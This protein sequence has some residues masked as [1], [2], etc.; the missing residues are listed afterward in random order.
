MTLA[1]LFVLLSLDS[2]AFRAGMMSAIT[3]VQMLQNNLRGMQSANLASAGRSL[4]YGLTVPIIAAAAAIGVFGS[5]L[6]SELARVQSVISTPADNGLAQVTQWRDG[7]Q[8]LAITLGRS[9]PEVAGGMYEIVSALGNIPNAMEYLTIAGR[10]AVAGQ[11]DIV[12]STKN[13]VLATRAWGDTSTD[14][15]KYMANL[16]SA[17]VRVGT[18]TESELGPAMANLLPI[19]RLYNVQ[20]ESLFSGIA[21][22]AGVSGSA[23]QAST[24]L[25]RAIISITSPNTALAGAYK[26]VGISSGE[27]LL[28]QKGLLGSFQAIMDISTRLNIPL[29]KLLGRVEAVKAVATLTE[30][31]LQNFRDNLADISN[32][33]QAVDLAFEGT[34]NGINK[35]AFQW[36][37][38]GVKMQVIAEDLYE[39][40]APASLK[41][42]EALD[43]MIGRLRSLADTISGMSTENVTRLMYALIGLAALGPTL[44]L[45]GSLISVFYGLRAATMLLGTALGSLLGPIGWVIL[46][47]IALWYAW[48]NN[49]GNIQGRTASA[50]EA[51]RGHLAPMGDALNDAT[52]AAGNLWTAFQSGDISGTLAA[53]DRLVLS[54]LNLGGQVVLTAIDAVGRFFDIDTG[55]IQEATQWVSNLYN[56]L[57]NAASAWERMG[58]LAGMT[59][60]V[61]LS[62]ALT[63]LPGQVDMT[64]RDRYVAETNAGNM[65]NVMSGLPSRSELMAQMT[66]WF[67]GVSA[68]F[69]K[70]YEQ[71]ITAAVKNTPIAPIIGPPTFK[72][73]QAGLRAQSFGPAFSPVITTGFTTGVNSANW[74]S[75]S[76]ALATKLTATTKQP[77]DAMV[78]AMQTQLGTALASDQIAGVVRPALESAINQAVTTTNFDQIG[79][80]FVTSMQDT[81]NQVKSAITNANLSAAM[82]SQVNLMILAF[83][84]RMATMLMSAR[85]IVAGVRQAFVGQGWSS[86]GMSISTGI[87][88]GISAGSGSIRAA[89]GAAARSAYTA[90][91]SALQA[92]SPSRLMMGPGMY[93]SQGLALGILNGIGYI[94]SAANRMIDPLR[95]VNIGG[96]G[97][98]A[99]AGTGAGGM[100][101]QIENHF[102]GSVTDDQVRNVEESAKT[103]ITQALQRR[104]L[105]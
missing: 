17:T 95:N 82:S 70:G 83:T 14:A 77:V 64:E 55:P 84:T 2:G 30:P 58:I 62:G 53:V 68:E 31:Q 21:T 97:G 5:R 48:Q 4:T 43:P 87:A 80:R 96:G 23:S 27:A 67:T 59:K 101:I 69:S 78:S 51:I 8:D 102:N 74:G 81:M 44:S 11:S 1:R 100:T 49:W 40:F 66:G 92:K 34:T 3:Q 33:A 88:A 71:S 7:I 99:F 45:I 24:Q 32:S 52:T 90:A 39:S 6:D 50:V 35:A 9:S 22:L 94:R 57:I 60:G 54:I 25:Q 89:A 37:A 79:A 105:L 61:D 41:V 42:L 91:M 13:L 86:V 38:A 47:I 104:G 73:V 65:R 36:A 12:T 98:F 85:T 75:V 103:G 16:A 63:P 56:A 18:V 72:A 46:G 15:V 20:L 29:N 93:A 28:S 19:G 76:S 10:A 26:K